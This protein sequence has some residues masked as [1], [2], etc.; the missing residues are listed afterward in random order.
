[1]VYRLTKHGSG[2]GPSASPF[3]HALTPHC[4]H[5]PFTLQLAVQVGISKGGDQDETDKKRLREFSESIDGVKRAY[6][7]LHKSHLGEC[8]LARAFFGLRLW[9][10][11]C[12][13]KWGLARRWNI[14]CLVW[15]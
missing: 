2:A 8:A 11:P 1:M 7:V 14:L 5:L 10:H 15:Y 9:I 6:G 4:H 12:T 3:Q 13:A